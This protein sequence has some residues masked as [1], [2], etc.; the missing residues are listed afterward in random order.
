[1]EGC[2]CV[3]PRWNNKVFNYEV[4]CIP[5]HSE[6]PP[7]GLSKLML[8]LHQIVAQCMNRNTHEQLLSPPEMRNLL[9]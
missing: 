9:P 6:H 7:G 2:L 3:L 4:W 8:V 1:M 5:S